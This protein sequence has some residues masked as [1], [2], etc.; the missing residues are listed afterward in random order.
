MKNL[1]KYT[2]DKSY[3]ELLLDHNFLRILSKEI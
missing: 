3:E 2:I 1:W